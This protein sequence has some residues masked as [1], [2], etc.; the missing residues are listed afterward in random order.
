M[1]VDSSAQRVG[2][3]GLKRRPRLQS[4]TNILLACLAAT[5]VFTGLTVQPS[6]ILYETLELLSVNTNSIAVDFHN[7][8]LRFVGFCSLFHLA[9]LTGERLVAIKFTMRYTYIVTKRNMKLA[10]FTL[11]VFLPSCEAI[12]RLTADKAA[13][14]RWR[15]QFL[16]AFAMLSCVLFI[17]SSYAI[18]YREALRHRKMIKTQ[19]LPQ[20]E[21]ER[22]VKEGK[23]LKTTVFVV[24][25]VVLCFVPVI[26]FLL[27]EMSVQFHSGEYFKSWVRTFVMLNSFLNPLIYCWRL[28]EMRRFV[29]RTR[30]RQV[31][32]D[33]SNQ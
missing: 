18:L 21:V 13:L 11:W 28:K 7:V 1:S 3:N 27:L 24:G 5:D 14:L 6:F 22:S 4:N 20:G 19:Q 15:L 25:A 2:D 32:V 8:F 29:F 12:L 23:A 16:I 30:N 10:V 9:L 31:A 33:H 26:L 17:S